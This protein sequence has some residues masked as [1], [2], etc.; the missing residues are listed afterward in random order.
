MKS[1]RF[2]VLIPAVLLSACAFAQATVG[3][4]VAREETREVA[5]FD[6]VE[7]SS[8]LSV[9]VK[10]GPKAVRVSGDENL[11]ALVR[12][13]VADGKLEV[14]LKEN[15]RIRNSSKVRITISTP[16]LKSVEASGG[17][18]VEAEAASTESFAAS[19]SSGSAIDVL[20]LD[21][22]QVAVEA[23][24]G[25]SVELKGRANA[26]AVEASSGSHVDCE[27][28]SLKSM[29]VEASSGSKVEANPSERIVAEVSSGS[30]VQVD[31][32]PAQRVVSST[33]GSEVVFGKN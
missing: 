5:D 2:A 11:V 6:G 28:L 7:V 23:S 18:A 13:Q 17:A 31:S 10:V 9:Q 33:G 12:T 29:T 3:N 24:S 1:L 26:L 25:A 32:S 8:G 22:K 14:G 15:S 21:A 16:Q 4:G 19:A 27:Q 20:N 30:S